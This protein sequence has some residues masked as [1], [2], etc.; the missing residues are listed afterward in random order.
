[1]DDLPEEVQ[2]LIEELDEAAEDEDEDA[3]KELTQKLLDTGADVGAITLKKLALLVMD[4]EEEM[5]RGW[6][7]VAIQIG[8][9]PFK[10]LIE[11]LAAGMSLIGKKYEKGEAFVPQLLIASSAMYGGMDLLSPYMKQ[12]E[13]NGSKQETVI[14]GT[15]EGDVHDIGK[16]LVKTMLSANGF[17]CVDL[18]NDV[19]A[20]K[21]IEAA[22][23]YRATAVSMSTLMTTTMAEMPRVVKMLADEG[24]RDKVLVM[25]GG[26]PITGGYAA[27]IGAD[28][29]PHDAASAANWLTEAIFDFP[30]ESAR[31]G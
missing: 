4:G 11:G 14:I 23:E 3:I 15:V 18:G 1:M 2:E 31:W 13:S 6:T 19:P 29:S 17:N 21:F 9:D 26:A 7:E 8:M 28:A 5:T 20:S 25:V 10:T 27:Q 16:N 30:S 12:D 22:K 24:I